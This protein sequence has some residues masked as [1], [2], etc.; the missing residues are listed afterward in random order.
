MGSVK[1]KNPLNPIVGISA[2]LV[3]L[4]T[5][6][7]VARSVLFPIFIVSVFMLLIVFGYGELLLKVGVAFLFIG[8]VMGGVT[9]LFTSDAEMVIQMMGRVFVF[10]ISALPIISIPY[11]NLTRCLA[12]L[13]FPRAITL[14]M[15]IAVRF[16]P[17]MRGELFNVRH[18][19]RTRGA[20]IAWYRPSCI[21][22]AFLIPLITRVISISDI[23]S[24]SLETRAFSL[25]GY[26]TVY[27]PVVFK[28]RDWMFT[29]MLASIIAGVV[30]FS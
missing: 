30:V 11:V 14:G 18:A 12:M 22:R 10:G 6:M 13:R 19:M 23:L 16:F 17:V 7:V 1:V 8:A 5:G 21:Y 29:G 20:N 24:L 9:F 25:D 26:S 2:S 27:K 15:M 3:I 28:L 4:V